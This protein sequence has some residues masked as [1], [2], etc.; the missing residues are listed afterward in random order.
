MY[1]FLDVE[2]NGKPLNNKAPFT[3]LNN[4]PRITQIAWAMCSD[5]ALLNKHVSLV[6][7]DGWTIPTEK[8]FTDNNMSTERC[9]EEGTP[10]VVLLEQMLEDA[11]KC[12]LII[13]HNILFDMNVLKAEL[14]RY[15]LSFKKELI[16]L[17]TMQTSTD[18]CKLPGKFG[19]YKWPSLEE[20]HMFLFKENFKG[21]HDAM[22]DVFIMAKCFFE[23]EKRGLYE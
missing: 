13:A 12:E 21:A 2:T 16:Q 10:L 18:Y 19:T 8:F 6:T 5:T 3:D 23:L 4:W 9:M 20:L 11:A 14:L 17:C 22:M 7:P 1:L 15:N